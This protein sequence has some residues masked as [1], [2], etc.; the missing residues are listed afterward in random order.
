MSEAGSYQHLITFQR[1]PLPEIQD[2][3]GAPQEQWADSFCVWAARERVATKEFPARDKRHEETSC[4]FRIRYRSDL[5]VA[6]VADQYQI[7]FVL[8]EDASPINHQTF[9]IYPPFDPTGRRREL[10][11]EAKEGI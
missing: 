3:A 11:I 6:K 10:W 1:K 4:R 9:D 2:A 7:I 5:A 8:D